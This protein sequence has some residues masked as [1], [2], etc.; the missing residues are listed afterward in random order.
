MRLYSCFPA[1]QVGYEETV[2]TTANSA[3]AS[4]V[5]IGTG[6]TTMATAS[7]QD[8]K[9]EGTDI[10]KEATISSVTQTVT[11]TSDS[12]AK[13]STEHKADTKTNTDN[14]DANTELSR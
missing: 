12:T 11:P 6:T 3:T 1:L 4:P 9:V 8:L 13:A 2:V 5:H 14:D 7:A 10:A